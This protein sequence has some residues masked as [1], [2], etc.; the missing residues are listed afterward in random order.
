MRLIESTPNLS[1]PLPRTTFTSKIVLET[2]LLDKFLADVEVVSD[3]ITLE[4]TVATSPD[5]KAVVVFSGDNDKC[6]IRVTMDESSN[7]KN[8]HE[9]MINENSRS[10]YS[11]DFISKMIR[12]VGAQSNSVIIEYS[13]N[14][15][16]RLEFMRPDMIKLQFFLAPGVQG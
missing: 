13:S 2:S 4:A 12:A 3:K 9:I 15:P 6:G 8:L 1:S 10:T 7:I 5:K 11:L 16:L 14:K